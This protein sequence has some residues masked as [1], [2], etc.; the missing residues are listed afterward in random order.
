MNAKNFL[1]FSVLLI[2]AIG[3]WYLARTWRPAE[4]VETTPDSGE[5]RYYLKSARILGTDVN[6]ELLYEIEAEFAEQLENND[7]SLEKVQISYST[8]SEVPWQINADTATISEDQ[9]QL[10]LRG[11]VIAI[12]KQGFAGEV[13]EIKSPDMLIEPDSYKAETNGRVQIKIG[14]HYLTATGMLALMQDN[15]LHLKSNVSGRFVP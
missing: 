5:N 2:A 9:K 14:T 13:T 6:G 8:G 7:I 3:S 15:K 11:N 10:V 12:S 1:T 4:I